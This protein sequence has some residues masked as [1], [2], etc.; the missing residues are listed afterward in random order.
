[1]TEE[2]L[3]F[4]ISCRNHEEHYYDY[5]EGPMAD[6]KVYA[7]VTDLIIGNI[8]RKDF[9]EK[10]AFKYPTHQIMIRHDA[11]NPMKLNYINY[12]R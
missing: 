12:R 2:W 5:V 1:M 10:A 11:L 7:F 9:W 3:D 6:D 8:T 4:I